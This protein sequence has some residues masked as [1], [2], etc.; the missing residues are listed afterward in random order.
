MLNHKVILINGIARSGTNI[1][2]NMLASHPAAFGSWAET[3]RIYAPWLLVIRGCA[4]RPF[5]LSE[6]IFRYA[7]LDPP[8]IPQVR[9]KSKPVLNA[10]GEHTMRYGSRGAK[11]GL[12]RDEI[13]ES[14]VPNI[15][16]IQAQTLSDADRTAFEAHAMPMLK[17]FGYA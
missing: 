10:Q 8:I 11:Y 16:E 4:R 13:R 1:L 14:L 3:S 6:Q 7:E 2:W 9:L 15:G 17:A 5:E 12:D